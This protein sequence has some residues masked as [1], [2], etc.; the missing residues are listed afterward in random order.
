MTCINSQYLLQCICS[1]GLDLMTDLSKTYTNNMYLG[2]HDLC[3]SNIFRR[4]S[5][6]GR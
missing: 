1:V 6:N 3:D 4:S 5:I 2:T